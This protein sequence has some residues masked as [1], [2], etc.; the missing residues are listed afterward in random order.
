MKRGLLLALLGR[1][2]EPR[3]ESNP[4]MND[5]NGKDLIRTSGCA[6]RAEKMPAQKAARLN[7][8]VEENEDVPPV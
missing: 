8:V 5:T 6:M 4:F 7:S 2:Q 1:E 3:A